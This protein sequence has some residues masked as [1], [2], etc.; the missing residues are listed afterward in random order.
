MIRKVVLLVCD[1]LG[2]RPVKELGDLTPLEAAATPNLDALAADAVCGYMC[3]LGRGKRPGSDTSHLAIMGYDPD[4]YYPGRGPVETAGI[5]LE[6]QH[7]DIALRGNFGTVDDKGA[8]ID[9]RGGRC[10]A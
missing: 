1:G 7:G 9:R 6:L 3:A 5:G 4:Q 8:I 10:R 2:D